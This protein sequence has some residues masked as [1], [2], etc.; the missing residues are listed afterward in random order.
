MFRSTI[1]VLLVLAPAV[2]AQE[3]EEALRARV[4]DL[5]DAGRY[6]EARILLDVL[7]RSTARVDEP[8]LR[9]LRS[10]EAEVERLRKAGDEA[11]AR[12][13]EERLAPMREQVAAR[14]SAQPEA[15]GLTGEAERL[16]NSAAELERLG[17]MADA[18]RL[19]GLAEQAEARAAEEKAREAREESRPAA[20]PERPPASRPDPSGLAERV[21]RL[22]ETIERLSRDL[23]E[24]RARLEPPK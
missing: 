3:S 12:V 5:V 23:A 8:M 24:L 16:R 10:M 15:P 6:S 11:G 14:S 18:A 19:R 1:A 9:Q 21:A 13:L 2:A 7:D 20:V 4:K 22:E 17:R